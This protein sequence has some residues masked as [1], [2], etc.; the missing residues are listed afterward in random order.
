MK[1]TGWIIFIAALGMM[2]S[3]LAI[4]ISNMKS[5]LETTTPEFV[6]SV[7]AHIGAVIAAFIGG[8]LIPS[9]S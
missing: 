8:K 3:L 5:W 9:N 6:G 1:R 7:M 2:C 4:D